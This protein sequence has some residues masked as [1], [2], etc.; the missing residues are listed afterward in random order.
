MGPPSEYASLRRGCPFAHV[1]LP[2][3]ATGYFATR[4]ADVRELLADPR[5]TRPSINA[6]PPAPGAGAFDGPDLITMM[7]LEGPRHAALRRAVAPAFSRSAVRARRG[8]MREMADGL[9]DDFVTWDRPADLVAGFAEPFPMMVL[10]ELAGIPYGDRDRFV[11]PADAGLGAML[12]L[13]RGR[14]ATA[15]LRDYI[16]ELVDLKRRKP[17]DDVLSDLVRRRDAGELTDEDLVC[18]GLSMLIAGYRTST[19]FLVDAVLALLSH[20]DQLD[21]LRADASLLPGAVEELLRHLP[22]MNANVVLVATEDVE[23]GGHRIAA[24][25]A[26]LPSIAAANRDD[27]VFPDADRLDLRRSPD[28]HLAFGRGTHNCVGSHLARA[29]LEIGLQAVLSRLPGLELAADPATL[30]WEDDSPAKSPLE[31]PVT[32]R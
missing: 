10:C 11:G 2:I 27:T 19:M 1:R 24:G 26:V 16:G 6:W 17:G 21:A 31:L 29:E 14:R 15:W 8:R 23:I 18:F 5:F 7:E 4:Y 20:P 28:N 3:D 32:W 12:D 13:E 25:E 30:P 9:L 22:V